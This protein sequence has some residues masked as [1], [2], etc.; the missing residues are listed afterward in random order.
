MA[1]RPA[2]AAPAFPP[3]VTGL[4]VLSWITLLVWDASPYARYMNH[5]DWTTIGLGATVCA[6]V[7]A[8]GWLVPVLLY[9]S[10]WLLMS[11]AMMLPTSLPL[12]RRFDQMI[13]G[14]SDRA[15]LH[16]LL[17]AGYLLAWV[18]FGVAA[19][20]LDRDARGARRLGLAR[21]TPLDARRCCAWLG[22]G[23]SV[24]EAEIS[25]PG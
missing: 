8:G 19:H 10:G 4:V 13:S 16:G 9:G 18:G 15:M 2:R 5:G 12:I 3:L 21:R 20:L 11:A 24:L 6:A 1:S 17:I 23:I 7:P 22:G 25:L 14:R